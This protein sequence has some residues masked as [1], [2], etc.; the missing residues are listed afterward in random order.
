MKIRKIYD[1]IMLGLI[2]KYVN[3]VAFDVSSDPEY[4]I[5]FVI[6]RKG[7][8]GAMGFA[9]TREEAIT[10]RDELDALINRR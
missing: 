6:S 5:D 8:D 1:K 4:D 7:T 10:L 2:G 3:Q 9:F